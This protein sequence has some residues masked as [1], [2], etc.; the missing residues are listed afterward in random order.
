[1]MRGLVV[2]WDKVYT[3]YDRNIIW[4][5]CIY[6]GRNHVPN[7]LMSSP[8][9]R[10]SMDKNVLFQNNLLSSRVKNF[11]ITDTEKIY[12]YSLGLSKLS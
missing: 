10:P 6:S 3:Y 9:L 5:C 4:V 1:M 7:R 2:Y 12:C 11:C 8:S